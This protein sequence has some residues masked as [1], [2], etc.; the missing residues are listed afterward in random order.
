MLGFYWAVLNPLVRG[1]IF[2][3]AFSIIVRVDSGYTPYFLFVL[4]GLLSWNLVSHAVADTTG[5]LV[6]HENLLAKAPFLGK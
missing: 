6:E 1:L 5:S 3:V 2:T 4:V